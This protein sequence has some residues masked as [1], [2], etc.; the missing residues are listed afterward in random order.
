MKRYTQWSG[1]KYLSLASPLGWHAGEFRHYVNYF[2]NENKFQSSIFV[3]LS[4]EIGHPRREVVP[5]VFLFFFFAIHN[6][7]QKTSVGPALLRLHCYTKTVDIGG[8]KGTLSAMWVGKVAKV[9]V[10]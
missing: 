5:H 10:S 2:K 4:A 8:K 6:R 1:K 7:L 3:Q 9:V